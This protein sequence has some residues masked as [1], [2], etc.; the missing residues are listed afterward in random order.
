MTLNSQYARVWSG[1]DSKVWLAKS[2]TTLPAAL[3]APT[4][5]LDAGWLT[6]DGIKYS[7]DKDVSE[8]NGFQGGGLIR[9]DVTKVV[10]GFN[11]V[12]A[13]DNW[14]AQ[15]IMYAGQLP[16]IASGVATTNIAAGQNN[17][18]VLAGVID[19]V[20]ATY[21]DRYVCSALSCIYTGETTLGKGGELKA[22]TVEARI[23]A[24]SF[25]ERR[26]DSPGVVA[27]DTAARAALV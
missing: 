6:E 21:T 16:T 14:L 1:A 10:Q 9:R 5:M 15:Y 20:D 2:G 13:E 8:I 3:A 23:V 27:M 18:L 24:G 11:F 25:A 19:L 26:T 17:Q 12:L 4:G 22:I 7:N